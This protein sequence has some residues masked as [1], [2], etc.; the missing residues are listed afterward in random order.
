[1]LRPLLHVL[2]AAAYLE[3]CRLASCWPMSLKVVMI[4]PAVVSA[5]YLPESL[6]QF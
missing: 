1:M 2:A 5:K 4:A 3:R 6:A